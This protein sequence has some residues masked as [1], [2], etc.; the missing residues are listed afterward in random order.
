MSIMHCVMLSFDLTQF[1]PLDINLQWNR[2]YRCT[3]KFIGTNCTSIQ[4]MVSY[5]EN[6]CMHITEQHPVWF[7]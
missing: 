6:H 3:D 7:Q 1:Q 4:K 5:L 2:T